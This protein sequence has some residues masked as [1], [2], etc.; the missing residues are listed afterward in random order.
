MNHERDLLGLNAILGRR[1]NLRRPERSEGP[2]RRLHGSTLRLLAM[3]SFAAL[4]MTEWMP[5]WFHVNQ[6]CSNKIPRDDSIA[7]CTYLVRLLLV[8]GKDTRIDVSSDRAR[9]AA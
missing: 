9:A 8:R 1:L 3:T 5:S 2:H 4:R 6:S 7:R